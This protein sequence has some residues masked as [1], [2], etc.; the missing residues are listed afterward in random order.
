MIL[1]VVAIGFYAIGIVGYYKLLYSVLDGATEESISHP[2]INIL[3]G[4]LA[5]V[6]PICAYYHLV[7]EA[8]R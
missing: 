1:L 4:L 3:F 8:V 5:L 2:L 7:K 6:W